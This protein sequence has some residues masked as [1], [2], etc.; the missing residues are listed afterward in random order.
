MST[1]KEKRPRGGAKGGLVSNDANE[2]IFVREPLGTM[3]AGIDWAENAQGVRI[4][5]LRE[6]DPP[7]LDDRTWFAEGRRVSDTRGITFAD[8][9]AFADFVNRY[10]VEEL[11]DMPLDVRRD[12]ADH[13]FIKGSFFAPQR[14][15]ALS[16]LQVA[17]PEPATSADVMRDLLALA[18]VEIAIED[19][20][21]EEPS[22]T[23]R[24]GL[25][26]IALGFTGTPEA[27]EAARFN[28]KETVCRLK[29]AVRNKEG[30]LRRAFKARYPM[31]SFLTEADIKK[32]C[33]TY[34]LAFV[35]VERYI[36]E[37]PEHCLRDI[38]GFGLR[39]ED[40]RW[41]VSWWG[42][43]IMDYNRR[44]EW[45]MFEEEGAA[46]DFKEGIPNA[47]EG[48]AVIGNRLSIL[49]PAEKVRLEP[50]ERISGSRIVK[51]D[52][53]VLCPVDGGYLVVTAWGDEANDP[54]VV[55]ENRN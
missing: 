19:D 1:K 46:T 41:W 37:I 23:E 7:R 18:N 30:E 2:R 22:A 49:A 42:G 55:N 17:P 32:L 5:I 3:S 40:K 36:G 44:R 8:N 15:A 14:R 20:A 16:T 12:I 9:S 39:E 26:H 51:D 28:E 54:A 24:T 13:F 53:I 34:S 48:S 38:E 50:H 45:S 10:T 29:R 6:I 11:A 33:A 27:K 25:R 4:L 21:P 47:S 43:G 35:E 52:P 31:H